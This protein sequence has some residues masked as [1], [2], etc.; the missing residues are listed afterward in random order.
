MLGLIEAP[1]LEIICFFASNSSHI[2]SRTCCAEAT[3]TQEIQVS[4][5]DGKY[6]LTLSYSF[7]E[8]FAKRLLA[9]RLAEKDVILAMIP[10]MV[11]MILDS[12]SCRN[13]L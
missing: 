1:F 9:K 4:Q 12:S 7:E 11:F 3:S 6:F 13:E 2:L 10:L 8:S 5:K